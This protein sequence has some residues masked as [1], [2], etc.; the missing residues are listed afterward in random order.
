MGRATGGKRCVALLAFSLLLAVACGGG[1][2]PP[3]RSPT[4]IPPRATSTAPE[5]TLDL[6]PPEPPGRDLIDLA[7]RFR[8]LPADSPRLARDTPPSLSV[9]DS[10]EFVLIDL[11]T[12]SVGSVVATL[13]YVSDH[14]Y[15]FVEEGIEVSPSTLAAI[16]S[17]FEKEVYPAVTAAFG[18]E[19][20]PGVDSDPRITLLHANLRGAGG[21][22]SASDEFP[23]AASPR[24]N[25]REMLYLDAGALS[26]GAAYNALVAHELQHLVHWNADADED[27]WVNE[28]LA[29][30]AAELVATATRG[31]QSFLLRPD[32][33]LNFWPAGPEDTSAHYAGSQLFFRY[34]LDRYGGR[35]RAAELLALPE[36]GTQGVNAYLKGFATTFE[37]I[38]ADWVIANYLDEPSGPY[39]HAGADL[40]VTIAT[41]I[42]RLGSG[43]GSVNQYAADYL[44]ID[45]PAGGAVFAFQGSQEV[46]LGP[47]PRDG[48]PSAGSGQAFWWSNRGDGIDSRLTREFDLTG[49]SQATLRFWTWFDTERDWDYAYVAASTD[50][51]RTWRALP[52][53]QTTD[54][55]PI[56]LAYGPGFTGASGGGDEPVWVQEQIDLTSF[57][58][59]KALLRLEYVTDDSANLG[60][61]AVDDIEV[62]ELGYRNDASTA[63]GWQAEGFQRIEGPLKQRFILQRIVRGEPNRV[64]RIELDAA[65]SARVPLDGPATIVVAA[66]SDGAIVPATYSWSLDAP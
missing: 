17:D 3:E 9:G 2:S 41:S 64:E 8:G 51:G 55:D 44:E 16:A 18:K 32:T 33:Q 62:P 58:G 50:A 27:A 60:G 22:F 34:L 53:T 35:E 25:E 14:A 29:Q 36:D 43:D 46:G 61:F 10:Q 7:R 12:P 66:V 37:D 26:P 1:A 4:T 45:P 23:R 65:N 15:L 24:S 49:L 47:P 42:G 59:Q 30:V 57:A 20:S 11:D 6:S 13:R 31:I 48:T 54:H 19:W 63:S 39:S 52:G 28:G 38:F 21:Y 56:G 40:R 5:P